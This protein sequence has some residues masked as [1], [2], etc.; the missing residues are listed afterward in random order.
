MKILPRFWLCVLLLPACAG[1][2]AAAPGAAPEKIAALSFLGDELVVD[3]ISRSILRPRE[4]TLDISPWKLDQRVREDLR[5]YVEAQPGKEYVTL[6]IDEGELEEALRV[7]ENRWRKTVGKYNQALLDLLFRR[8][9]EQGITGFFLVTKAERLENFPLHKGAVGIYC[10]DR[11]DKA[12][13]AYPYFAFDFSYWNVTQKKRVFQASVNPGHTKHFAFAECKQVAEM[14]DHVA[15]LEAPA[16]D[17]LSGI[18][19]KLMEQMG[20]ESL[21]KP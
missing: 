6:A 13:R 2:P 14:K 18:W 16:K 3:V 8:A 10:F 12:A 19:A 7:R 11:R 15:E 9:G 4:N 21:P 1:R 17:A 20:W 5:A